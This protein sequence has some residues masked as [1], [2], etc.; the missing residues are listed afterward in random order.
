MEKHGTPRCQARITAPAPPLQQE[1]PVP[2]PLT[3]SP[4]CGH[5]R[6]HKPHAASHPRRLR[7][8]LGIAEHRGRAVEGGGRRP[9]RLGNGAGMPGGAARHL[10]KVLHGVVAVP[11]VHGQ[12]VRCLEWISGVALTAPRHVTSPHGVC[13]PSP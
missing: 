3:A 5:I 9:R 2:S 13:A 4:T 7:Q 11:L 1:L 10:Q 12:Q 8:L 6:L